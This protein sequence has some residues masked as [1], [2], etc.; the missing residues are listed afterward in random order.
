MEE[1]GDTLLTNQEMQCVTNFCAKEGSNVRTNSI[2]S[3]HHA[4]PKA[5]QCLVFPPMFYHQ[6]FM[7]RR[8]Y[9]C[10]NATWILL[11]ITF[12]EGYMSLGLLVTTSKC[13]NLTYNT[14]DIR[15]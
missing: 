10:G 3:R 5:L 11:R 12:V 15:L 8:L 2:I 13:L 9:K 7:M 4:T 6:E 14:S 1:S